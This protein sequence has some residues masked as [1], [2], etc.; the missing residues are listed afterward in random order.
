VSEKEHDKDEGPKTIKSAFKTKKENDLS[1]SPIVFDPIVTY[2]P[3]VPYPPVLD[4][5]FSSKKDK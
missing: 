1:H 5:Q 3:R 4:A 2:K